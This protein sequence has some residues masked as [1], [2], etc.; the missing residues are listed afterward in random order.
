MKK[1]EDYLA[2]VKTAN[3]GTSYRDLQGHGRG[4]NVGK[5]LVKRKGVM[6]GRSSHELRRACLKTEKKKG[7]SQKEGGG[8]EVGGKD[9]KKVWLT[10]G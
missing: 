2:G 10:S 4:R 9:E 6:A 1:R 5:K 3:A 8:G 7:K